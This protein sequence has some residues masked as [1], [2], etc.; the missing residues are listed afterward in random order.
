MRLERVDVVAGDGGHHGCDFCA[1]T[2]P[3]TVAYPIRPIDGCWTPRPAWWL[4]C[5]EC[6][7]LVCETRRDS[8]L[9]VRLLPA[10]RS[11]LHGARCR[12]SA[13]V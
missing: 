6:A 8:W 1:Q 13:T 7:Q 11:L 2:Q 12:L 9:G 5:A 4:A 3:A 10:T